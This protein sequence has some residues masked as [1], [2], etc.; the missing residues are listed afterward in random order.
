MYSRET[1]D[2]FL[3]PRNVGQV[4]GG[5]LGEAQ[6]PDCGDTVRISLRVEAGQVA[7]ARFRSQGCSGAIAASS[8]A[9]VLLTGKTLDEA[10][11]L[12]AE[13]IEALLGGLPP[14]KHGCAEMAAAA[15]RAAVA[16]A[17]AASG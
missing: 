16:Q 15:A 4:D 5:P 1:M 11:S 8:A 10:A 2:H 7:E 12:G 9:T 13:A 6:N 17:R 14:A 3:K